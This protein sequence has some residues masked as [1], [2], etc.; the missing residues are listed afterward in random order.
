MLFFWHTGVLHPWAIHSVNINSLILILGNVWEICLPF[1]IQ[2][3]K[4]SEGEIGQDVT[5]DVSSGE[6]VFEESRDKSGY[7]K[8]MPL[9]CV[10]LRISWKI[11]THTQRNIYPVLKMVGACSLKNPKYLRFC[12]SVLNLRKI[13]PVNNE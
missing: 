10:C 5:T 2:K 3:M 1:R 9:S 13:V 8:I 12:L 4:T 6:L 7:L 11:I